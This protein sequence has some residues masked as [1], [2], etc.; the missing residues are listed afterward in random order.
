MESK[1]CLIYNYAQHYRLGVFKLMD[2]E[3]DIDFYFGDKMA[4][5]KKL[6]YNE[7]SGFKQELKNVKLLSNF[8]WQRGVISLFFK[9]YRTYLMLGEY[10]CLSTW[11]ILLFS[12]FSS[13]R[14]YLWSHGWYGKETRV[15]SF[16]KRIFF[17]MADGVFLYGDYAKRLMLE[18]GFNQDKLHVIYNSL[19][20]E[21]QILIRYSLKSSD[22][23]KD[24]FGNNDPIVIFIGRLTKIKKL[25]LILKAQKQLLDIGRPFNLVIIGDGDERNS[26]HEEVVTF[27]LG[28]FVWFVGKL[29]DEKM[30]A[31]YVYNADLCVSPGNVGLTAMHTLMYG[32]PVITHDNFTMQMPEFESIQ[33]YV[34][35]DFFTEGNVDDLALKIK[36]WLERN[37]GREIIRKNCY[38]IIDRFYNPSYQTLVIKGVIGDKS[39]VS[40]L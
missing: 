9:K 14:V 33:S 26:L 31:E 13:K 29:Y 23:Y 11:I 40:N 15:V 16:I 7:L 27:G 8:Y 12:K 2:K 20:Y 35:G 19:N 5:V 38:E 30:I 3:M 4:D 6:D 10:Y 18:E 39:K 36:Q 32:T 24:Y 21:E 22:I 28:D 25:H 17:K 1:T 34:T 37:E